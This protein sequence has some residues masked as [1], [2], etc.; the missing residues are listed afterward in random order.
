M[1]LTAFTLALALPLAAVPLH[2]AIMAG[3]VIG[4]DEAQIRSA[5]ESN[6]YI[7]NEIERE[8]DE[9]EVE[10]HLDGQEFEIELSATTGTVLEIELEDDEDGDDD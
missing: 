8:D 1:K 4:T 5:L 7:V 3:D 6:G 10:A 2:A 9:I